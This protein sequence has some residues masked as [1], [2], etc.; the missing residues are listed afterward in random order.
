[1]QRSATI[2]YNFK[3]KGKNTIFKKDGVPSFLE[4]FFYLS[5]NLGDDQNYTAL[6][7]RIDLTVDDE[8]I[9]LKLSDQIHTK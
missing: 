2:F 5:L 1:M 3:L 7:F 4:K 6:E 9:S 8:C